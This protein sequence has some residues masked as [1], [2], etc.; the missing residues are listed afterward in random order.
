[1]WSGLVL[2]AS[3]TWPRVDPGLFPRGK[4]AGWYLEAAESMRYV[5]K[6]M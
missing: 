6:V 1:M 2:I 5:P 3:Q 4:G